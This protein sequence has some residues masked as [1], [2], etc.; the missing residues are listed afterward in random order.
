M[1]AILPSSVE[2]QGASSAEDSFARR[3][4]LPSL[5]VRRARREATLRRH[6]FPSG[7]TDGKRL[8]AWREC[9]PPCPHVTAAALG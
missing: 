8:L 3:A 6:A 1:S 5:A 7:F 4:I 2:C 9:A